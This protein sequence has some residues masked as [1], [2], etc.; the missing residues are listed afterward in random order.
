MRGIR[1]LCHRRCRTRWLQH[2]DIDRSTQASREAFLD[3][4]GNALEKL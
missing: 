1:A 4:V 3:R 2:Y